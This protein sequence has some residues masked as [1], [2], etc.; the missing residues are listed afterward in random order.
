DNVQVEGPVGPLEAD[1]Q[2]YTYRDIHH[3]LEVIDFFT[4]IAAREKEQAGKRRPLWGML[5]RPPARFL[6]MYL[7]KRGYR[8]GFAGFIIAGLAAFYVFLK[9]AKLWERRALRQR[10]LDPDHMPRYWRGPEWR[11]PR[12]AAEPG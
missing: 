2:H 6:R 11:P 1:L 9:D 5:L 10:G 3:H 4:D 7:W 12:R 8:D